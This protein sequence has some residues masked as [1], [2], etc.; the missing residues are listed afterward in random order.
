[1]GIDRIIAESG[2]ARMTLFLMDYAS[3][4]RIKVWGKARIVEGD[5]DL[6]RRLQDPGYPGKVERAIIFEVEAW[7]VNCP[8]HIHRRFPESAVA[9][10]I[11]R[12]Q[13]RIKEL[14]TRLADLRSRTA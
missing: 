9:P 1:V 7:D 6:I 13:D 2:V 4:Q 5:A 3:R 11:E 10:V 14:E 8:Q 12:L